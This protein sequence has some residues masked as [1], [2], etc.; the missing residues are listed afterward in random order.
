M[1]R[2]SELAAYNAQRERTKAAD[3]RHE[4]MMRR[5]CARG[6]KTVAQVRAMSNRD[7]EAFIVAHR[8]GGP[9]DQG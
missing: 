5:V 9:H 2:R 3:A 8:D 6:G 4:E 1:V 7:K